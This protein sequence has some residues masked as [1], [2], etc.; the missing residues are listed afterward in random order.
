MIRRFEHL[1]EQTLA[2]PPRQRMAIGWGHNGTPRTYRLV[3]PPA[4][5]VRLAAALLTS[6]A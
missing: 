6:L 1:V 2:A 3:R 4:W 5:P